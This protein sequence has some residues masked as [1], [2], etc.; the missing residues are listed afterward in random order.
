M[1]PGS[2]AH[3]PVA[4]SRQSCAT[5]RQPAA[6]VCPLDILGCP[7][8]RNRLGLPRGKDHE[9]PLRTVTRIPPS[10]RLSQ[11]LCLG[12]RDEVISAASAVASLI[13]SVAKEVLP[14]RYASRV[15]TGSCGDIKTSVIKRVITLSL[16]SQAPLSAVV[17]SL[18]SPCSR[19]AFVPE[20]VT[21]IGA[22][23]LRA[24]P[25]PASLEWRWL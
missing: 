14:V 3:H 8:L 25:Q 18:A 21:D 1:L 6:Q 20:T 5:G 10:L 4:F 13:P 7:S 19:V 2:L 15:E 11:G 12:V 24:N 9:F 23:Q 16:T 17:E 22:G